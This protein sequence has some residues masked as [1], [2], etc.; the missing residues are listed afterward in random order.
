MNPKINIA[1][2][3]LK[4]ITDEVSYRE[5][6]AIIGNLIDHKLTKEEGYFFE[7]VSILVHEYEQKHYPIDA[8]TFDET[9]RH[10]IDEGILTDRDLKHCFGSKEK[11]F[12]VLEKKRYLTTHMIR[13]LVKVRYTHFSASEIIKFITSY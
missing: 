4:P 3:Q 9:V 12:E 6:L 1:D 5:G 13:K 8:L 7:A 2:Y 11:A 10:Y